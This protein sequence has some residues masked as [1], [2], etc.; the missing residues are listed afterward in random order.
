MRISRRRLAGTVIAAASFAAMAAGPAS[1]GSNSAH[2]YG[3]SADGS[4]TYG[5]DGWFTHDGEI[6]HLDDVCKD[7]WSAVMK[8]DVEPF[9]TGGGYDWSMRNDLSAAGGVVTVNKSYAEGTAVCVQAGIS[10]S[11]ETEWGGFGTWR[12]GTA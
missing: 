8:V 9:K 4:C 3:S 10:P 12:C 1:A 7:G 5:S 6:F 2:A 11:G